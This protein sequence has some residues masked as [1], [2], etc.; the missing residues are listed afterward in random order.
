[1]Q[2]FAPMPAVVPMTDVHM[3][4]AINHVEPEDYFAPVADTSEPEQL[5]NDEDFTERY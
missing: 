5:F 1:M 2:R 3:A 4:S